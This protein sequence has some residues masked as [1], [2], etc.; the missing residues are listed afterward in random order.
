MITDDVNTIQTDTQLKALWQ[1]MQALSHEPKATLN[2]EDLKAPHNGSWSSLSGKRILLTGGAGYLGRYLLQVCSEISLG[3]EL[4][5]A[6]DM[7]PWSDQESAIL[8]TQF[9]S[10]STRLEFVQGAVED[11]ALLENI[12]AKHRLEMVIHA[13]AHK[14]LPELEQSPV[15]A[16]I[17]NTWASFLLAEFVH[18][19]S[20]ERLIYIS[21]DKA[22][23]PSSIYG[24]SKLWPEQHLAYRAVQHPKNQLS[25]QHL[26]NHYS[27][28]RLGNLLGSTGS[29]LQLWEQEFARTQ[30]ITLRS[31]DLMRYFI[32]PEMAAWSIWQIAVSSHKN[33]RWVIDSGTPWSMK[34][35]GLAWLRLKGV[36]DPENHLNYTQLL[37]GEKLTEALWESSDQPI[38][39]GVA[40]LNYVPM[41]TIENWSKTQLNHHQQSIEALKT[42]VGSSA[43]HQK[44][45]GHDQAR[46]WFKHYALQP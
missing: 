41:N 8:K 23:E 40:G 28:I 1:R 32:L 30:K 33:K 27:I 31:G 35:L 15:K 25:H 6:L 44:S 29:V 34:D 14:Y 46:T 16:L 43:K 42:L 17:Q 21:T 3:P 7:R 45:V 9:A 13:A 24:L 39:S 20:I 5:V 36:K 11:L 4:I 38:S 26:K 18:N 12:H 37:P 2:S 10:R 22:T 19:H